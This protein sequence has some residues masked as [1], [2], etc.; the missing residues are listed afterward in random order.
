[1]Q[2]EFEKQ[3]QQKMEELNFTPSEP[4]WLNIEKQIRNKKDK[5]RLFIWLPILIAFLSGSLFIVYNSQKRSTYVPK[6]YAKV[7]SN[8]TVVTYNNSNH[9]NNI[10]ENNVEGNKES[11]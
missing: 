3:V 11:I 8:E 10:K 9:I 2:N 5:R 6:V 7:K 4:V 1:M